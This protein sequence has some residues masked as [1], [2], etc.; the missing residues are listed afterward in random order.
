[1]IEQRR[2]TIAGQ[3]ESTV[4]ITEHKRITVLSPLHIYWSC[5]EGDP[6]RRV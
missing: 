4:T 1:M 3:V 5:E 2:D 6:V